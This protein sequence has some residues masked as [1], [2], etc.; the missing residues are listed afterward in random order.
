MVTELPQW[1]C[2][3]CGRNAYE[4]AEFHAAGGQLAKFFDVQNTK[5]TTVSCRKCAFTE[6]YKCPKS[7]LSN[8]MDFLF[9]G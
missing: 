6:I 2:P 4:V 9:G 5:F 8:V 1:T 3:K 7:E